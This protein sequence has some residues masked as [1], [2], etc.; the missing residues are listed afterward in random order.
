M[1]NMMLLAPVC[2]FV[3][4]TPENENN[5]PEMNRMKERRKQH[6]HECNGEITIN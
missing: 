3:T 5:K 4:R 1:K 6:S 2:L